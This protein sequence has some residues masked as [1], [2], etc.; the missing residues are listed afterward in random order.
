MHGLDNSKER[1]RYTRDHTGCFSPHSM[2]SMNG[3][4]WYISWSRYT[5]LMRERSVEVMLCL[6]PLCNLGRGEM[7]LKNYTD[8]RMVVVEAA[9]LSHVQKWW[10]TQESPVKTAQQ[11]KVLWH[12]Q[13]DP[14]LVPGVQ[15]QMPKWWLACDPRKV[16]RRNG[17]RATWKRTA[18]NPGVGV[19][20]D[21]G[22]SMRQRS[23]RGL[24][25]VV[26]CQTR[27]GPVCYVCPSTYWYAKQ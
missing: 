6:L 5:S 19:V 22:E 9:S 13:E 26:L 10:W 27:A 1:H 8:T 21:T 12:E 3:I 18:S 17:K 25:N 23:G 24:P 14:S 4:L 16:G 2:S 11:K 20:A 15:G 7:S